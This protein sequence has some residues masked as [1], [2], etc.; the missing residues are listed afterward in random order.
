VIAFSS[1]EDP[2]GRWNFYKIDG[3]PLNDPFWSDYPNVSISTKDLFITT[4]L[5]DSNGDW[6]YSMVFQITK[7]NGYSGLP[8]RWKFYANPLN[9]DSTKAFNLVP[10]Q[11][12]WDKLIGPG[13]H[14]VSNEPLGGDK[15]NYYQITNSLDQNPELRSYQTKGLMTSLAPNGRQKGSTNILNTFDSRIWSALYSGGIIHMG[16]HVNTDHGDVGLLYGRYSISD[17]KVDAT[18]LTDTFI[19]YGFPSFS[20]FGKLEDSDTILVNY[21]FSGA[22]TFASQQQRTVTGRGNEFKWSDPITLKAGESVISALPGSEQRWGDYS[23]ACRRFLSSRIESWVVGMHAETRN[24]ATWIGQ[25]APKGSSDTQLKTEFVA[26]KTTTSKDS[27]ITFQDLTKATVTSRK[28]ILPGAIPSSSQENNPKV[29]YPSNGAYDVTL[30][31]QTDLGADTLVKK[32]FIH[33][34]DK[35]VKPVADF[36]QDK[37]TVLA[38]QKV[39]FISN[40][41]GEV[42]HKKWTFAGGVPVNSQADTVDVTYNY[43]GS[44]LVA[45]LAENTA[46]VSLKNKS[47]AVTVIAPSSTIETLEMETI[48]YPSPLTT[49]LTA[50]LDMRC[51]K[52]NDYTIDL[53]DSKAIVVH[54]LY[55]DRINAGLNRLTFDSPW[56]KPGVYYIKITSEGKQ[57][58]CPFLVN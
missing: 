13:M 35:L 27:I 33:I 31:V 36:F 56:L 3:N 24:Y 30:I 52:S 16:G 39:R 2:T 43:P 51:T 42:I 21:L 4:L 5:R 20:T 40:I 58:I 48:F 1:T 54:R 49:G 10:T 18:I 37:D 12:G 44:F 34:Q 55:N 17:L 41:T 19:D 28:W 6:N 23:T 22:N 15:Y 7:D 26:D 9:A 38:G 8:L 25:L 47:K 32:S 29:T 14:L 53:L 11:N 50:T 45:L 57:K 46:G